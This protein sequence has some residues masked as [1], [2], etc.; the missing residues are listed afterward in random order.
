L[1]LGEIVG[2]EYNGNFVGSEVE[3]RIRNLVGEYE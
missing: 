1:V 2:K 3:E